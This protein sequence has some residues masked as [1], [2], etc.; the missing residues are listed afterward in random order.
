MVLRRVKNTGITK[1]ASFHAIGLARE[2][3]R[4]LGWAPSAA[5][6]L[7]ANGR[8]GP[9]SRRPRRRRRH[10]ALAERSPC[11]QLGRSEQRTPPDDGRLWAAGDPPPRAGNAVDVLIE[12]AAYFPALEHAI[13]CAR[14]SVLIAGWCITPGFALVRAEPPVLLREL[15]GE[16][17]ESVD[18]RVLLWAGAPMAVFAPRRASVREGRD[19]LVRGTRIKAAL[20]S[21]E[22]P[23]HCHHE[24]LVV[25]DDEVAFVGGIRP[26]GPRR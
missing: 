17:A 20:D 10:R 6:R 26:N 23:M 16:A 21:N 1:A 4:V 15:L 25:I 18:V 19:E 24:K 14:R 12:G 11:P 9:S 13:R 7:S 8:G 22:R 3:E 5:Y 2:H